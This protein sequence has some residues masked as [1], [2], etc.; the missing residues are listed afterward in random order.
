MVAIAARAVRAGQSTSLEFRNWAIPSG[1]VQW[2]GAFDGRRVEA[3]APLG[4][5]PGLPPPPGLEFPG[6]LDA[7]PLNALT[8]TAAMQQPRGLDA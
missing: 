4:L 5:V 3:V 2:L 6:L 1:S 8:T 7:P